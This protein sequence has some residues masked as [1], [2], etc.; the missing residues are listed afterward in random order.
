MDRA[1]TMKVDKQNERK[2]IQQNYLQRDVRI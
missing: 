2:I 1:Q